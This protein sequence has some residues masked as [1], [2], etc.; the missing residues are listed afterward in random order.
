MIEIL[1]NFFFEILYKIL[2][3]FLFM[4]A[5]FDKLT[6]SKSNQMFHK[7]VQV[8][9]CWYLVNKHWKRRRKKLWLLKVT[10]GHQPPFHLIGL[11]AG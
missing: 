8:G 2:I 9:K 6:L 3:I 11:L 10:L 5:Y 7:D 4:K 1:E